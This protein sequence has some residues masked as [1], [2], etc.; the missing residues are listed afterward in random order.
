M[1]F[2]NNVLKNRRRTIHVRCEP[3]F[4]SFSQRLKPHPLRA[5]LKKKNLLTKNDKQTRPPPS[6]LAP[7]PPKKKRK[8]IPT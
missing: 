2:Q 8:N 6:P 4:N 7:Q 3:P 1:V 5:L